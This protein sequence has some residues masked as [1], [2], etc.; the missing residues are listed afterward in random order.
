VTETLYDILDVDPQ[1]DAESIRAAYRRL[2]LKYHP[3]L[4]PTLE[5]ATKSMIKINLAYEILDSPEKR[6]AYD[7]ATPW[8]GDDDGRGYRRY[9]E[10]SREEQV[11]YIQRPSGVLRITRFPVLSSTIKSVGYDHKSK[12]LVV[13]FYRGGMYWYEG[14]PDKVYQKLMNAPSIE[15]Y[16]SLNIAYR[17]SFQRV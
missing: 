13:Q 3:D 14:V 9:G 1:A 16:F 17:Y 6:A 12:I 15:K 10:Y 7:N 4:N 8:N 5:D 2:A 11:S